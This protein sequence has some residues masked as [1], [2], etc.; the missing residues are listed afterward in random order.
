MNIV[1]VTTTSHE[2]DPSDNNDTWSV[3]INRTST[4]L[5]NKTCTS[6]PWG[7]VDIG[8]NITFTIQVTNNGDTQLLVL[9]LVDTYDPFYLEYIEATPVPDNV[10][11]TL[12]TLEW[13]DLTY[14]VPINQGESATVEMKFK[15]KTQ[16]KTENLADVDDAYFANEEDYSANDTAEIRIIAKVGGTVYVNPLYRAAPL[17]CTLALLLGLAVA[18]RKGF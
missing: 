8:N 9:P 2:L 10:N 14:G 11:E 5:V 6:H 1:N 7:S 15:T 4:L 17:A 18:G 16:G 12:G 13:L 3:R